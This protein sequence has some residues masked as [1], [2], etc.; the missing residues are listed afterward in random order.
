MGSVPQM[1]QGLRRRSGQAIGIDF[2]IG[3]TIFLATVSLGFIYTN[4]LAVPSSP[5]SDNVQRSALDATQEFRELNQWTVYRTP[6]SID[7]GYSEQQYPLEILYSFPED[8]DSNSTAVIQ[9]DGRTRSQT[10]P[11][12]NE[13]VVYTNLSGTEKELDITYTRGTSLTD[14]PYEERS[15]RSD[16]AVWNDDMNITVDQD[17]ISSLVFEGQDLIIDSSFTEGSTTLDY[18]DG[19]MR[20]TVIY[21]DAGKKF[22][23][24]FGQDNRI[25]I[26]Q[27]D[28]SA[29]SVYSIDLDDSF[30]EL[31]V[32]NHSGDSR[33][34]DINESGTVYSGRADVADLHDQ[35]GTTYSLAMMHEG[36]EVTVEN[37][38]GDL[39]A[40]LTISTSDASSLILPH[41]GDETAIESQ[42]GLFFDPPTT[43]VLPRD[44][45]EGL[46]MQQVDT[47]A[48]GQP[49]VLRDTLGLGG[50][51]FNVTIEGKTTMGEQLPGSQ[52]VAVIQTPTSILGRLGNTTLTTIRVSVWL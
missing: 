19:R 33:S 31:Y 45:Q 16:D 50:L 3:L 6:V 37:N 30:N 36:M 14:L 48:D 26:R 22:L 41:T 38:S 34:I 12:L 20:T 18:I 9:D 2:A 11:R 52:Q 17:G 28:G 4:S 13:T 46:S 47:F 10:D 27:E 7:T 21:D 32:A 8:L 23:R 5:F 15:H 39:N 51:G 49:A 24:S 40:D 44:R 29:P 1:V 25:R 35:G 42:I 43:H